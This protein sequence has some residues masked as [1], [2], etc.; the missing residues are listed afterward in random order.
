MCLYFALMYKTL[1]G[2]KWTDL[3]Q[4]AVLPDD[5]CSVNDF[6]PPVIESM[7]DADILTTARMSLKGLKSVGKLRQGLVLSDI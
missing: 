5:E 3:Y 4:T 2:Y 7:E 6:Q 1:G